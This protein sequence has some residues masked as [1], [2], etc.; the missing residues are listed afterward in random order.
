[1]AAASVLC[2]G[3]ILWDN[4]ANQLGKSLAEVIDWTSY[5]GGAPANV[6]C[7]LVKLGTAAGFLGCVGQDESGAE[8]VTLLKS[9]DVNIEGLQ[10]HPTAPTRKVYVTRTEGGDRTF[11]G[12]GKH[13]TAEFADAYLSAAALPESLFVG[14][15]YLVTGTLSLAYPKSR[16]AL[17]R[18]IALAQQQ[19]TKIMV[20]V[21]WRPV[22]WS[23]A[24]TAK[25]L[26]AEVLSQA[27]FIKLT[28]EEA[29]WFFGSS[30]PDSI[31]AAYPQVQGVLITAGEKGCSYWLRADPG[32]INSEQA[33]SGQ[34]NS[35]QVSR[36]DIPA[37]SVKVVDTTGA[38]DAFLAGFLHQLVAHQPNLSDPAQAQQVVR[39]AS[40]VGALTTLDAGAIAAQPTPQAV[41]EFLQ[42][43]GN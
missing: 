14:V 40:A 31:I 18:A 29:E 1:M 43:V 17:Y 19:G 35:E 2:I 25:P 26:I 20:D 38:G 21:N 8:L 16:E 42:S 3:E 7:A 15:Q 10:Q 11:A 22:F 28:D 23:S 32:Q 36:G 12:F 9:L 30:D 27:D 6:A 13:D 24:E 39:Y 4:L 33:N 41:D 34:A 5:P 37:F